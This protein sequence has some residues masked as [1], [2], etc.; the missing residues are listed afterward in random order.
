ML[1]V[2]DFAAA[3]IRHLLERSNAS[4][5]GL[6]IARASTGGPLKVFLAQAPAP[7]DTV[8]FAADGVRVFL[9]EE[10]A[11]LLGDKM[12]DVTIGVRGRIE[13]FTTDA[14]QPIEPGR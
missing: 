14:R 10:A 13:F 3:A 4:G 12:L 5:G 7:D 2:T 9:D 11:G 6:R 8:V 1:T